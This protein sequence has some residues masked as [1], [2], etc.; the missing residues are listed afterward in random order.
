[1][2]HIYILYNLLFILIKKYFSKNQDF[3]TQIAVLSL[4]KAHFISEQYN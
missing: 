4:V 2:P 3:L 1:M